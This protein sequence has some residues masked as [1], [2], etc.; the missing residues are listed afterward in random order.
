MTRTL[1]RGLAESGHQV[2]VI[3]LSQAGESAPDFECDE[4]V[5]IW[6]L[7]EPA[8]R[9]GWVRG[10]YELYRT[11]AHWAHLGLVDLV[12]VPDY[13]GLAA[14]WPALPV[15]VVA[16]LHGSGTYFAVEMG[17]N[18]KWHTALT[19]RA[20]LRRADYHCSCSRYT[21]D[22]S[23]KLFGL[24]KQI[25]VI[26][27]PVVTPEIHARVPRSSGRVVFSGTLTAKKGV[28]SLM[29]AWNIVS[30][31]AGGAELHLFG[32]DGRTAAGTSMKDY[33]ISCLSE[34]GRKSVHFHGH[35][36]A[37]RL[38]AAFRSA[39]LAVF[40]SYS[41]AFALGPMEAMAESCPTI[42]TSRCSGPELIQHGE[43]GLLVDPDAAG[44]IARNILRVIR[45]TN[46]ARELGLAGQKSIEQ[47]F[48]V[49]V[50]VDRNVAFYENCVSAHLHSVRKNHLNSSV[51]QIAQ[52][53]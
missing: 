11:I 48:S 32:K 41:E 36:D 31:E 20:S 21:A 46:L 43:N 39:G 5:K 30:A 34:Q 53:N 15:P 49:P 12:E 16:R 40:P 10:R 8:G 9:F 38:R 7:T 17:Q 52:G 2:R 14:G 51:A 1:A 35:V 27:N 42:Y 3:G 23:A 4:G 29:R 13:Q 18:P 28:V 45:D 26:Y 22:R 24:R 19:E 33:L 25:E 37:E 50:L 47:R 44:E 6:R